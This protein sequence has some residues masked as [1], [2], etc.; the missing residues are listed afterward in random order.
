MRFR[1]V[2][3]SFFALGTAAC[4][5]ADDT[6]GIAPVLTFPTGLRPA[7]DADATIVLRL[8][9]PQPTTVTAPWQDHET[10]VNDL[11]P[12][13]YTIRASLSGNETTALNFSGFVQARVQAGKTSSVTVPMNPVTTPTP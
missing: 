13:N 11:L 2:L 12:G 10:R 7:A 6:G 8:Y 3:L 1:I 4:G 5:T 9:G